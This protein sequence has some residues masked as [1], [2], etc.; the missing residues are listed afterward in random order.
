MRAE[1]HNVIITNVYVMYTADS[2]HLYRTKADSVVTRLLT[3]NG[4]KQ[5]AMYNVR[6][7]G[8]LWRLLM[9]GINVDTVRV[10]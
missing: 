3:F 2:A 6:I 9:S 1:M 10:C 4:V 8:V 5:S 7:M